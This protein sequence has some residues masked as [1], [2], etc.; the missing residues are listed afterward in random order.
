MRV[1]LV[2]ILPFENGIFPEIHQAAIKGY[3]WTPPY[4]K[5]D[6]V[7][8]RQHFPRFT[9]RTRGTWNLEAL[10][11]PFMAKWVKITV[12]IGPR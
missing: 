8:H 9:L 2:I 6:T 10:P 7:H 3:Q 5:Q 12:I 11:V 1:P 4:S